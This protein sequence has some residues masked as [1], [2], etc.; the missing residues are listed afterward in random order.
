MRVATVPESHSF[1]KMATWPSCRAP[2]SGTREPA[3]RVTAMSKNEAS[4][5]LRV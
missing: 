5:P 2:A 3:V 4:V 1:P